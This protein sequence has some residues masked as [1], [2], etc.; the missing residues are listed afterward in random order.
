MEHRKFRVAITECE[1]TQLMYA[2]PVNNLT[3]GSLVL[4]TK[5]TIEG[6]LTIEPTSYHGQHVCYL[7]SKLA[8]Y[9]ISIVIFPS[10]F[11]KAVR[12]CTVDN[13]I[14]IDL[15]GNIVMD[16]VWDFE[17]KSGRL[18]IKPHIPS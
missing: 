7:V 13:S 18:G 12:S 1:G 17:S 4:G 5:D 16:S 3:K 2:H 10:T 8:K 9:P 14:S 6:T 15:N 11:Y